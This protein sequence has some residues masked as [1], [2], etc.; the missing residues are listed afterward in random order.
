MINEFS[1]FILEDGEEDR[2][3]ISMD[4]ELEHTMR[5]RR[6]IGGV[7][8]VPIEIDG[9]SAILDQ[10]MVE[11]SPRLGVRVGVFRFAPSPQEIERSSE[12]R[13]RIHGIERMV[14]NV[15]NYIRIHFD[16]ED[17]VQVDIESSD[18]NL[19]SV[20]SALVLIRH[21]DPFFILDR[22]EMII[23]SNQAVK[24]DSGDFRIRVTHVPATRGGG[25]TSQRA[26]VLDHFTTV[27]AEVL[28]KT[29][30]LHGIT[31]DLHPFCGVAA[32]I[33]GK[34]IADSKGQ[35]LTRAGNVEWKRL[36]RTKT[37]R[38]KCYEIVKECKLG[39]I[40]K[41]ISLGQ[42]R[43]LAQS[44]SFQSYKIIVYS[45]KNYNL[46]ETTENEIL[47]WKGTIMLLLDDTCHF[48]LITRPNAFFGKEGHYCQTI[49][50]LQVRQST[51]SAM[52]LCV[53][54]VRPLF[55][56]SHQ[57]LKLFGVSSA[58]VHF[59]AKFVMNDIS[60]PVHHR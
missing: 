57:K 54:S 39:S 59:T 25:Y 10:H 42:L 34:A 48:S 20:T 49:N 19:G 5:S 4:D 11:V 44:R 3:S 26:A 21:A 55:A 14:M 37:L 1:Y 46:P 24:V 38:K 16:P 7:E 18:L 36:N 23:Q 31:R 2:V 52:L 13:A 53:N 35:L 29:K 56:V 50:F 27:S 30:A 45:T 22:M 40:S 60:I 33:L 51:T 17:R 6:Q 9:D 58:N 32:L 15:Y 12:E 47:G 8:P 28:K 43:T 41:G